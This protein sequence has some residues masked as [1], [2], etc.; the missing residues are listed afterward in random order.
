MRG[1]TLQRQLTGGKKRPAI[2]VE[3]GQLR[4]GFTVVFRING[5]KALQ[6]MGGGGGAGIECKPKNNVSLEVWKPDEPS[7]HCLESQRETGGIHVSGPHPQGKP[8]AGI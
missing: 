7:Q 8:K 2:S 5:P 4:A 3:R 1:L 6:E